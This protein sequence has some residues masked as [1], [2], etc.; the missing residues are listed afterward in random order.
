M[1]LVADS[2][3]SNTNWVVL[4]TY[5]IVNSFTTK[6]LSPYFVDKEFINQELSNN[7]P[8]N[9]NSEEI[10]KVYFYGSGCS[11]ENLNTIVENGLK[12]FFQ[13]AEI[14]INTDLLA[15]ARSLF[16][17]EE[18]IAVICGTGSNTCYYDGSNIIKNI[19]SL[20]FIFG[21][22]GGG[23]YLGK[24]FITDFLN[25]ELPSDIK[26]KFIKEYNL[27]ASEIL[28]RVYK[29]PNP[30]SFL[31]SFANYIAKNS[32]NEYFNQLILRNFNDLFEK[33][34]CKYDGFKNHNIRFTGS[35]AFHFE[36]HLKIIA[37]KHKATVDLIIQNPIDRLAQFHLNNKQD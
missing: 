23:D 37:K 8:R 12:A 7:F 11:S 31:A 4:N 36:K 20:G 30:N 6:G 19:K 9:L 24:L 5:K 25:N 32:G 26:N 34:I 16:F 29:K 33:H 28:N 15:A 10:K 22:E 1:I 13:K 27:N 35:V 18:G 2:G 3:S 17:N 21:D 14:E